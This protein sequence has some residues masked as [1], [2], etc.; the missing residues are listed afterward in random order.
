M[1]N[2][3]RAEHTKTKLR[4]ALLDALQDMPWEKLTVV[5][6]TYRANLSRKTF[7][8]YYQD[9]Y[10]LATDCYYIYCIREFETGSFDKDNIS[11]RTNAYLQ[12]LVSQLDFYRRNRNFA[13]MISATALSTSYF[14]RL[15]DCNLQLFRNYMDYAVLEKKQ[16]NDVSLKELFSRC[17]FAVHQT[18]AQNW[19]MNDCKEP[20]ESVAAC[21]HYL[22]IRIADSIDLY[23]STTTPWIEAVLNFAPL[24][25]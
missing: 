4:N 16:I 14:S 15:V 23:T 12:Q 18:I 22:G 2:E 6:I 25:N 13:T 1:K 19:L 17:I 24:T 9:I 10:D 3:E 21:M 20:V 5:E 8:F 7:Y 11:A